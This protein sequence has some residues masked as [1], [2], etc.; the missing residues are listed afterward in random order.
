MCNRSKAV[1]PYKG[2]EREDP[3][4]IKCLPMAKTTAYAMARQRYNS[5]L[6]IYGKFD[7]EGPSGTGAFYMHVQADEYG[8]ER[9]E[10]GAFD[11]DEEIILEIY[12]M[13]DM[14]G[15]NQLERGQHGT[16]GMYVKRGCRCNQC[17]EA[18]RAYQA[19]WQR[20]KYN[21]NIRGI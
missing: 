20:K 16:R 15:R 21:H 9:I 17:V 1:L 13:A 6:S 4:M 14:R 5:L 2:R 10:I 7:P 18:N 11:E 19:A 3:M 8:P 12:P